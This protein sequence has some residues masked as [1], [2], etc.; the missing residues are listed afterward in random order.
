MIHYLFSLHFLNLSLCRELNLLLIIKHSKL[1]RIILL[2]WSIHRYDV[3][4]SFGTQVNNKI[5]K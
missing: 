1:L 5:I 2:P 3:Q 4:I